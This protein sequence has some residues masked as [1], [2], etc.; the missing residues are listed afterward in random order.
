M[1]VLGVFLGFFLGLFFIFYFF[2][3]REKERV[4]KLGREQNLEKLLF[5]WFE[6]CLGLFI[7]PTR[8]TRWW[9]LEGRRH[10][11]AQKWM[12]PDTPGKILAS[13]L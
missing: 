6:G 2:F 3:G 13:Y 7:A 1:C 8:F 11:K 12:D 4:E 5:F 9:P 10:Q